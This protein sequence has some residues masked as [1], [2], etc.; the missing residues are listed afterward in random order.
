MVG[1]LNTCVGYTLFALL[2]WLGLPYMVAIGLATVMGVCFN[3]QST[4]H[5][6]FK[7]APMSRLGY[8]FGVYGVIYALNVIAMAALLHIGFNIYIANALII[9]PLA[10]IAYVLQQKFVFNT[11]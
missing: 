7:G 6:V 2:V 11:L 3:F 10:L 5:F 9:L 1:A 4:G 8:F